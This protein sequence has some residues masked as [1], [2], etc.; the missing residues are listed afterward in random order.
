MYRRAPRRTR[1]AALAGAGSNNGFWLQETDSVLN[2][3]GQLI[4]GTIAGNSF[5]SLTISNG[6]GVTVQKDIFIGNNATASYNSVLVTGA[7]PA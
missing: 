6:G 7:A 4:L 1:I 2:G 5:N 3:N